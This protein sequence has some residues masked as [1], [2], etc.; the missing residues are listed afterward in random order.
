MR[1]RFWKREPGLEP[2]RRTDDAR[3]RDWLRELEDGEAAAIRVDAGWT[4][5]EIAERLGVVPSLVSRWERGEREPSSRIAVKYA[6]LLRDL[7]LLRDRE[8]EG[9]L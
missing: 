4:Q 3:L 6:L 1:L 5:T 7:S 9:V 8:I 2:D